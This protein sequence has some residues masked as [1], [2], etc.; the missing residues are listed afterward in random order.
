MLNFLQGFSYGL[1]LS[2]I[3]WFCIG[4]LRPELAVP[5][6]NPSRW[7]V[8]LR[9]WLVLPGAAFLLWLTS[10]WGGFG[11]S[12]AG[13]VAGLAAVAVSLP[14]ER[15]WHRWRAK[16]ADRLLR[17]EQARDA[18][19]HGVTELNPNNPPADADALVLDLCRVKG[20]L[21]QVG[22]IEYAGQADRLYARYDRIDGLL[23]QRFSDGEL[24]AQR[25]VAVVRHV[26]GAAVERLA[27]MAEE[28]AAIAGLDARFANQR[29]ARG[30]MLDPAEREALERRLRLIADTRSRLEQL[31]ASNETALTALDELVVALARLDT[32]KP[33]HKVSAEQALEDLQRFSQRTAD[34]GHSARRAEGEKG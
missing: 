32:G 4:L 1:F 16:R 11:P 24:A 9:Y 6:L 34:Y 28:G 19:E 23:R 31:A 25:G 17:Q 15:W 20:R 12:L 27:G 14:A 30:D 29:L 3:P 5:T 7:Q 22:L 10:L 21:Q 18:R 33:R 2:C 26:C 13:W 8:V